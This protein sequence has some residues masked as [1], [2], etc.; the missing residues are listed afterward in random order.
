ME[1]LILFRPNRAKSNLIASI[2]SF[3]VSNG[4]LVLTHLIKIKLKV[5]V[6]CRVFSVLFQKRIEEEICDYYF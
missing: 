2:L 6:V 3:S 4:L 5:S 1:K